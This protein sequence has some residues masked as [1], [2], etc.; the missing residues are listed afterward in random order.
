MGT[1]IFFIGLFILTGGPLIR[2][3]VYAAATTWL[4][5]SSCMW[6]M[7]SSC[8]LTN[9]TSAHRRWIDENS[10][11]A[12]TLVIT[13]ILKAASQHILGVDDHV[14][15]H[16]AAFECVPEH[17]SLHPCAARNCSVR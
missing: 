2:H 6:L 8:M 3:A 9:L 17:T 5:G 1:L 12:Q 4:M 11:P 14:I 16:V 7:G 15:D 13:G 10:V